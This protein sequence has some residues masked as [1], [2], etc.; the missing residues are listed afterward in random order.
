M[1]S[2]EIGSVSIITSKC[3][4]HQ[5]PSNGWQDLHCPDCLAYSGSSPMFLPPA[6][7]LSAEDHLG[8][9]TLISEAVAAV[10]LPI[11]YL[12]APKGIDFCV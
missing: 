2:R 10:R 11:K 4:T 3:E 6:L 9:N 12:E 5:E 7:L 1:T 8:L